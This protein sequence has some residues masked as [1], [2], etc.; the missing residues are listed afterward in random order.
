MV[1]GRAVYSLAN[2]KG[3]WYVT[4]LDG[5]DDG[6]GVRGLRLRAGAG[7][8]AAAAVVPRGMEA[9]AVH[10]E[11][12]RS[13]PARHAGRGDERESGVEAVRGGCAGHRRVRARGAAG[14]MEWDHYFSGGGDSAQQSKLFRLNGAGAVAVDYADLCAACGAS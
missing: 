2:S 9:A 5:V 10:G 1:E 12:E 13:E 3:D 6:G 8:G 4:S 11:V 14:F 7:G